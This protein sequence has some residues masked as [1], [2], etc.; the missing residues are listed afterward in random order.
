VR[1]V[2]EIASRLTASGWSDGGAVTVTLTPAAGGPPV[3]ATGRLEAGQ[4]AAVV[5]I[6]AAS[7]GAGAWHVA[8]RAT[9]AARGPRAPA[10]PIESAADVTPSSAR[11][12]GDAR[13]FRAASAMRAT[14]RPVADFTYRRTER[15]HVEWPLLE[16]VDRREARLLD[17]QGGVLP[18][19]PAVSDI[20]IEGAG[21]AVAVDLLLSSLAEGDYVLELTAH[22]GA[23]SERQLVAFRV[24]R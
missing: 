20:Q 11:I 6:P 9:S 3:S 19:T 23:E 24:T 17:R 22:R 5:E 2:A 12:L 15:L 4:R 10:G 13:P 21:P 16:T 1:V 14:P 18:G 7:A 8:V